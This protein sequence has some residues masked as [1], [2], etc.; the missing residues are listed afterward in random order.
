MQLLCKHIY[1]GH[2]GPVYVVLPKDNTHFFS[3]GSDGIIAQWDYENPNQATAIALLNTPVYSLN[4][5]SIQDQVW[6]GTAEGNIHIL[7]VTKKLEIKQI[8]LQAKG[9]FRIEYL[10]G[11]FWVLGGNGTLYVFD[12]GAN[13]LHQKDLSESKLRSI[14]IFEGSICV[15]DSGGQIF[16][17]NSDNLEIVDRFIAHNPSVYDMLVLHGFLY[18]C[19]RDG[20]IRKWDRENTLIWEI[21]AHNYAIYSLQELDGKL[22]SSSRDRKIKIWDLDGKFKGKTFPELGVKGSINSCKVWNNGVLAASDDKL[23]RFF[24]LKGV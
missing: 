16:K 3:A 2:T 22:V 18:T 14:V 8:A 5:R 20:H 12:E 6:V 1:A 23:L 24:H 15:G 9:I 11:K 10:L 17:L 13:L 7:D 4:F 21:P 19:G